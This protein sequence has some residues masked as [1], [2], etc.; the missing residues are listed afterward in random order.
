VKRN[1]AVLAITGLMAGCASIPERVE[2]LA[3]TQVPRT[4]IDFRDGRTLEQI[5]GKRFETSTSLSVTFADDQFSLSHVRLLR[6]RLEAALGEQIGSRVV[7]LRQFE[8]SST[9]AFS[10]PGGLSGPV[11]RPAGVSG[12]EMFAG[13]LLAGVLIMGI[14]SAKAGRNLRSLLRIE[15][16]GTEIGGGAWK[17]V[18]ASE[19][20]SGLSTVVVESIDDLIGKTKEHL[21]GLGGAKQEPSK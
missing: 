2:L 11:Q 17:T 19:V 8:V 9:H 14:E 16:D 20:A 21:A 1:L 15:L 3:F 7:V 4:R 13:G 10:M 5:A 6:T 12:G 18:G